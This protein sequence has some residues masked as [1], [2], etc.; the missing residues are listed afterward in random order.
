[1]YKAATAHAIQAS[2]PESVLRNMSVDIF[3]PNLGKYMH[4]L[5]DYSIPHA[6]KAIGFDIHRP[7]WQTNK[8]TN[9]EGET[10]NA[11]KTAA[12]WL[13]VLPPP[14][15]GFSPFGCEWPP[16]VRVRLETPGEAQNIYL[17]YAIKDRKEN[18]HFQNKKWEKFLCMDTDGCHL[19]TQ[20][21]AKDLENY[22]HAGK[23]YAST[24]LKYCFF[25]G[26]HKSKKDEPASRH[27]RRGRNAPNI[28]T[29][30]NLLGSNT[31]CKWFELGE[32]LHVKEGKTCPYIHTKDPRTIYCKLERKG[33]FCT[34]GQACL[35]NHN[36]N[37][38]AGAST[39]NSNTALPALMPPI[40][41]TAPKPKSSKPLTDD[42]LESMNE[43]AATIFR[44]IFQH[45]Y[46]PI[47][48]DTFDSTLG[49]PGEGPAA[50]IASYNINGAR[51][52]LKAV[53]IAANAN[54]L[55]AL[56]LQE[57]HTYVDGW[58]T[59]NSGLRSTSLGFG[60]LPFV[61]PANANDS[62][63]GTAILIKKIIQI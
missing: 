20:A 49:F 52:K 62:K 25:N 17:Q 2:I 6:F 36:K 5:A 7:H 51:D 56:L 24:T 1:M 18:P 16:A 46:T 60:W 54:G 14:N 47:Y 55:D 45:A 43:C 38:S 11:G 40:A 8:L 29:F 33:A 61:S 21:A 9:E 19:Y 30:L 22:C 26:D 41:T 59:A 13:T 23:A 53:L 50:K 3:L 37:G 32:C 58:D 57:I 4:L 48:A 44:L 39:S 34:N 10:M 12:F 15:T 63:G 35:Y 42:D 28:S 31:P 27:P